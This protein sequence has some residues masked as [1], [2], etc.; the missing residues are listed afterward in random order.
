[1]IQG[2]L[3]SATEASSKAR[4][5]QQI[6]TNYLNSIVPALEQQT[7]VT[8]D[9]LDSNETITAIRYE[10]LQSKLQDL[11][12]SRQRSLDTVA[13]QC[14]Y[15]EPGGEKR[16]TANPDAQM[17]YAILWAALIRAHPHKSLPH[18]LKGLRAEP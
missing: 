7:T 17:M 4:L 2:G 8:V 10:D 1:M 18:H 13:T 16:G 12:T 9:L 6:G 3:F 14:A 5:S 11:Y 15:L